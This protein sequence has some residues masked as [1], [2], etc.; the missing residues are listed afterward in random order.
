M[1]ESYYGL[2]GLPF[3]LGPDPRFFF[4]SRVHQKAM[5][6]LTY[7]L[8]QGEGF[9][10]IT[11]DIGAGIPAEVAKDGELVLGRVLVDGVAVGVA[12]EQVA[13]VMHPDRTFLGLGLALDVGYHLVHG[14]TPHSHAG[15]FDVAMVIHLIVVAGMALCMAGVVVAGISSARSARNLRRQDR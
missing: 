9:I 7:G 1:Y 6:Y 15:A 3:Q 14:I 8:N 13:A 5:A 4:G 11:G 12:E 2:T 10:I